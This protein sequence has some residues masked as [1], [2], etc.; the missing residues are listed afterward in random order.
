MAQRKFMFVYIG[1][2]LLA[3]CVNHRNEKGQ[4]CSTFFDP[5]SLASAAF[6]VSPTICRGMDVESV[7]ND[8]KEQ[9]DQTSDWTDTTLSDLRYAKTA[10]ANG[11]KDQATDAAASAR[12]DARTARKSADVVKEQ[13][14]WA[15]YYVPNHPKTKSILEYAIKADSLA[16]SAENTAAEA[17]KLAKP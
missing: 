14:R 8:A 6:G 5:V 13:A 11:W 1:V 3:G 12:Q 7:A 9:T 16:V 10:K 4:N 17:T 15:T 2:F